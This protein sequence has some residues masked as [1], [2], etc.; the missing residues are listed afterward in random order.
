MIANVPVSGAQAAGGWP[1]SLPLLEELV[2]FP[3]VSRDPNLDLIHY[4]R[5][6]LAGMGVGG[7]VIP[8]PDGRK[9]NLLAKVG[10]GD[11]PGLILSGHTDVVP[12]DGQEWRTDPFAATRL[13]DTIVGR[14]TA[15]MKGFVA[16]VL[17]AVPSMLAARLAEPI[18]LALSYDE[19][20]GCT[21][22]GGMVAR[23]ADLPARPRGCIVGE[24]TQMRVAIG[25]KGG[26]VYRCTVRG[27]EVHSSLQP[28]GVNA[29]EQAAR[30]IS[31]IRELAQGLQRDERRHPGLEIPYTTMQTATISGGLAPNVVPADCSFRFDVRYLPWTDPDA[32]VASIEHFIEREVLPEMR[33]MAPEASIRIE[34][35]GNVPHLEP[36]SDSAFAAEVSALAGDAQPPHHVAFGTEAGLFSAIGIPTVICGPG[37]I[38]QAHRPDEWLALDQLAACDAFLDRLIA[39]RTKM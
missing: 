28:H 17:A 31:H 12:V 23:I 22:V 34:R 13:G 38:D 8:S 10:G 29:V 4:C 36:P 7:D 16:A 35:T 9:A 39:A 14:G 27:R 1:R 3:T 5:A 30:I 37:S 18:Y 26:S 11:G 25:H 32:L 2:A 21:G 20:V 6:Y 15:D 19:E 33:A 24:P